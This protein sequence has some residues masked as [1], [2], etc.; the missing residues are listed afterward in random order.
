[1]TDFLRH[2]RIVPVLASFGRGKRVIRENF[3]TRLRTVSEDAQDA[4]TK[5]SAVEVMKW[6]TSDETNEIVHKV[7]LI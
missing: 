3:A 6:A 4:Y 2:R 5:R 7:S 1:M